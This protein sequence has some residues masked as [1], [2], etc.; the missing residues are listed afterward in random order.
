MNPAFLLASSLFLASPPMHGANDARVRPGARAGAAKEARI[1]DIHGAARLRAESLRWNLD[2]QNPGLVVRVEVRNAR[3]E[4]L[5]VEARRFV[6]APPESPGIP[7]KSLSSRKPQPQ[8]GVDP[9][10]LESHLGVR[11]PARSQAD[12]W[13]PFST[14]KTHEA[15]QLLY[16][17]DAQ[18][19]VLNESKPGFEAD[20]KRAYQD[21]K[22]S[23]FSLARE[24]LRLLAE[25]TPGASDRIGKTLQ[26]LAQRLRRNHQYVLEDR[27]LALMLPYA[28][29]PAW[30]HARRKELLRPQARS[31]KPTGLRQPTRSWAYHQ[32]RAERL[33]VQKDPIERVP[34]S[35]E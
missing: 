4:D 7:A 11:I 23:R 19:V 30:V 27:V 31:T 26:R 13:V 17:G 12:L 10:F 33:S 16:V 1:H 29:N 6:L 21:L 18:A 5:F 9:V 32:R 34:T 20:L 14:E 25:A 22:E 28:P 24:R 35:F 2:P 3:K 8:G 15:F